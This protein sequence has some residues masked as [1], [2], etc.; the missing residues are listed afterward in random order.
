MVKIGAKIRLRE[1]ILDSPGRTILNLLK[2][3]NS[4]YRDCRFGKY[5]E[6]SVDSLDEEQALATVRKAADVLQQSFGRNPG[7]GSYKMKLKKTGILQFPGSNCDWDVFAA[8]K[9]FLPEFISYRDRFSVKEYRAF[10]LPGGFS[11]GDY[12]RAGALAAR[13]PAMEDIQAGAKK[14]Y[15]VLGICNGFQILCEAG[16][17]PGALLGNE[18]LR[19]IDKK[20]RLCPQRK[21]TFWGIDSSVCRLPIAHG[22]GRY[23]INR[24]GLKKLLD[25]QQVW[26]TYENNPNGSLHDIAGITDKTGCIAG[27]M[28][29]PERAVASWMGGVDGC[30]FFQHLAA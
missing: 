14:G 1:E 8:L 3:Q 6:L 28:P 23:F 21:D 13:S 26:L 18:S 24:E 9:D 29:H 7:A 11:Y 19:F 5:I 30:R 10:V 12:L 4:S 20:V 25:K 27:L 22:E 15:P 17:L 2:D 16:L